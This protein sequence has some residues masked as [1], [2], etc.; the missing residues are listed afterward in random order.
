MDGA[1]VRGR[2]LGEA[3]AAARGRKKSP[4]E[5]DGADAGRYMIVRRGA[6]D[7]HNDGSLR[8]LEALKGASNAAACRA[9]AE[10]GTESDTERLKNNE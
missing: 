6:A 9:A 7:E 2:A 10:R 5:I 8:K 3:D 4:V 1:G